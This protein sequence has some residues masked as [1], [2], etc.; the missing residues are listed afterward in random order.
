[1]YA[2][3][4]PLPYR[5]AEHCTSPWAQRGAHHLVIDDVRDLSLPVPAMDALPAWRPTPDLVAQVLQPLPDLRPW[6]PGSPQAVPTPPEQPVTPVQLLIPPK[7]LAHK[8]CA[9]LWNAAHLADNPRIT[10]AAR[11]DGRCSSAAHCP[12]EVPWWPP[13][14]SWPADEYA[15]AQRVRGIATRVVMDLGSDQFL[16]VTDALTQ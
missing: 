16:V 7:E 5:S 2:V 12:G 14:Q 8:V 11:D 10:G 6:P 9:E 1:M 15:A 4:P 3:S 13:P